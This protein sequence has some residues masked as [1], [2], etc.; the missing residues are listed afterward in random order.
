MHKNANAIAIKTNLSLAT[1]KELLS[2]GWTYEEV[3][4]QPARWVSPVAKIERI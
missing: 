3:L 1:C 2:K 4:N